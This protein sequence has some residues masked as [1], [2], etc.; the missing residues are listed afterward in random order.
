MSDAINSISS[1]KSHLYGAGNV[2][3]YMAHKGPDEIDIFKQK[4]HNVDLSGVSA[5][6]H[7]QATA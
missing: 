5:F 4:E 1:D 3:A 2:G 7:P 6:C